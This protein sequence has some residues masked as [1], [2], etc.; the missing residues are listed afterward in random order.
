MADDAD[1][2]ANARLRDAAIRR[3]IRLER[4]SNNEARRILALLKRVEDDLLR[5][6]AELEPGSAGL[7]RADA[8]MDSVRDQ[9]RQAFAQVQGVLSGDLLDL[10]E[11]EIESAL[12]SFRSAVPIDVLFAAPP[13]AT[14]HAA[15]LSRPFQGRLLREW[16]AS[17][18]ESQGRRVRDAVRIGLV[19]GESIPAIMRRLRGTRANRFKDG[20]LEINRR[21]AEA[22]VRTAVTH[23]SNFA[24]QRTFERNANIVKSV[25]WV[26]TLDGR[27]TPICRS[28]DGRVYPVDSGPRPPAHVG[29]RSVMAPV[30]KSFRELGLDIDEI[31]PGAR[32]SMNG[33]VPATTTYNE[34]LATQSVEFQNE[35]LGPTRGR[36]FREGGI[37]MDRF[38]NNRG[39]LYTLEELRRRE[40]RAFDAAGV[41]GAG[42]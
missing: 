23:T 39:R 10:T 21:S 40:G 11:D 16:M 35:V 14:V 41:A 24:R 2:G 4:Y 8:I 29:C 13:A 18:E 36:L 3:R 33:Q 42:A 25:Q 30:T 20:V 27:T 5:K 19:E 6:M 12:A 1:P 38:V 32:A 7:A 9:A 37:T 34:W 15:A 26:A 17:L 28:R 22:V 31:P